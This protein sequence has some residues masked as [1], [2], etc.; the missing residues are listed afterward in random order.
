MKKINS[1][2][3]AVGLLWVLFL[4]LTES[5][6]SH[7][8]LVPGTEC[9]SF[10]NFLTQLSGEWLFILIP[11]FIF[12]LLYIKIN[13]DVYQR[14][15]VFSYLWLTIAIFL[16]VITSHTNGGYVGT[17]DAT[18]VFMFT[19]ALYILISLKIGLKGLSK[20]STQNRI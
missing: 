4:Y 15:S 19:E 16:N 10:R 6:F 17:S 2:A 12:S 1:I 7:P 5:I 8:C 9:N 20:S 3:S 11:F 14:W 13:D 18:Y